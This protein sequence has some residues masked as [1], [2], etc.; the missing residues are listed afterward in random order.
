MKSSPVSAGLSVRFGA[1]AGEGEAV[2]LPVPLLAGEPVE[3]VIPGLG[4]IAP[5]AGFR[6]FARDGLLMGVADEPRRSDLSAQ[7]QDAYARL[8]AAAG[9]HQLVR[10]W[11]Y[12]PE[13]NRAGPDGLENYRAFCRGRSLAF[14]S[15]FGSDYRH[16]LPAA[17]AVGG[18]PDRLSVVFLAARGEPVHF[19]NP[20]QMPAYDYPAE[21][22]PRSPS[23]A[24]ATRVEAGGFRLVCVS[25]TAAIKGHETVA[26]G[27]LAGQVDCLL[28]N[29]AVLS[30]RCGLEGFLGADGDWTRHVKVYLRHP[31]D[32]SAVAARLDG[33]LCRPGDRV[34]WL[35][36]DICREALLVE[37]E[38]TLVAR[39]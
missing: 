25:G 23:F 13:I 30:A 21:H 35:Q 12:V 7:G 5:R 39:S 28:D 6:L 31:S 29:L 34:T 17:S 4:E 1:A 32:L 33:R 22:G 18:A 16:R 24:R 11:N 38:A 2:H 14:E 15:G 27:D 10:I 20:V 3:Q 8:L 36:S 19:E 9:D 37:A 26:E